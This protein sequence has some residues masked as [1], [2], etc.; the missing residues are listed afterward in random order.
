MRLVLALEFSIA[1]SAAGISVEVFCHER[2]LLTA[3]TGSLCS[4]D[5]S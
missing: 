4:C 1:A 5:F 3:R 2:A